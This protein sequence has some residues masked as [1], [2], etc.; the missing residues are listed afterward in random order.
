MGMEIDEVVEKG[1]ST[2]KRNGAQI[3]AASVYPLLL[4]KNQYSHIRGGKRKPPEN[5][6]FQPSD[7]DLV[8]KLQPS[9]HRILISYLFMPFLL[10]LPLWSLTTPTSIPTRSERGIAVVKEGSRNETRMRSYE[11]Y[12]KLQKSKTVE[13]PENL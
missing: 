5:G 9:G 8:F 11:S 4:K 12:Q 13:T 7:L 3:P 10:K 2:P 1:C 6:Y